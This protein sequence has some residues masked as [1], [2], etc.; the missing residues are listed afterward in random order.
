MIDVKASAA[1]TASGLRPLR[2]AGRD[3]TQEAEEDYR[4]LRP[5]S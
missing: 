4:A 2:P 1:I 5:A 3:T